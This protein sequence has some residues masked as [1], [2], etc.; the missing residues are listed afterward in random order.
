MKNLLGKSVLA[1]ILLIFGGV[2]VVAFAGI[3]F[4]ANYFNS[5]TAI[6]RVETSLLYLTQANANEMDTFLS[7]LARIPVS[8]AATVQADPLKDEAAL[9]ER[10]RQILLANPDIYGT[11]VAFEPR[12]VYPINNISP[13]I[14]GM[15]KARPTTSSLAPIAMSIGNGSGTP[16]P[17]IRKNRCGR[18]LITMPGR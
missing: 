6:A 1:R 16:N 9:K 11:A 13:P 3:A 8:L 15:I 12:T 18:L 17:V 5:T 10:M 7:S 14:T 2:S 4:A